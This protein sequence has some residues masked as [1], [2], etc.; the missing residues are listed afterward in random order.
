M[1]I[2]RECCVLIMLSIDITSLFLAAT[3]SIF[4]GQLI[5]LPRV[6]DVACDALIT[7]VLFLG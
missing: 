1:K 7:G 3:I 6:Y 2:N 5:N 4:I